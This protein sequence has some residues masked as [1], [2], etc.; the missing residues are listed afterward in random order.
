MRGVTKSNSKASE[1]RCSREVMDRKL[2]KGRVWRESKGS[3]VR[4]SRRS[5]ERGTRGEKEGN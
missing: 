1:G 3:E 5:E 2:E 4:G